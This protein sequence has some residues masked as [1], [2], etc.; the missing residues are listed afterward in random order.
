MRNLRAP[1]AKRVPEIMATFTTNLRKSDLP[2][3]LSAAD[4]HSLYVRGGKRLLDIVASLA[5]LVITS[6]L[7]ALSALLVRLTSRGPV[8]FRQT[9]VGYYGR[10]FTL[11]KFRTMVEGSETLGSAV[12]VDHD[13]RLTPVGNFLRRT[14]LDEL[15][16]FIN[17][18]RGEMSFVG[19][20][21]RVPSEIDMDDPSERILLSVRPGLTSYASIHHRME[22]D[23]CAR[24]P[25]PQT[26]H[27][28][29]LLP[30]K[31]SLDC[32][33]VQNLTLGLDVELL[34]LTF[35][36]VCVPG[37]SLTKGVRIFGQEVWPYDRGGQM[38]LELAVYAGAAWMAYSF[39]YE[40]GF[41]PL[42]QRQLWLYIAFIPALRVGVNR[43]LRIYDMMW[44]YVTVEDAAHV[45]MALA[46]VSLAL[47]A[48]RLG[49]PTSSWVATMFHVPLSV[50][51]LEYTLALAGALGLRGLRRMLYMLHHQYQPLPEEPRRVLILGAGLLGL[52][53]AQ[54]IRPY[55]HIDLVGFLDDDPT[56]DGR[57]LA[58]CRVLGNSGNL[59]SLC[60]RHK[61]T[62]LVICAKT[63]D[64][65][66]LLDLFRRCEILRIKLHR[67]PRLDQI[68]RGETEPAMTAR[69]PL[70]LATLRREVPE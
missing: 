41:P 53:T 68:L 36:L 32:Q 2:G 38:L 21:P 37:K 23:Y 40:A 39:R 8:L 24:H 48:L 29:E 35:M 5:G 22:A 70:S 49:L 66:Q 47:Y 54:D 33:Y 61:V 18:L 16:Q 3:A 13:R 58:G 15:P 6:P 10:R 27:R 52:T 59:E 25:N 12:V 63:I 30:Q 62:D 64:P 55:P 20:R 9:R 14:K 28:T 69:R 44:R 50:I 7:L 60:A 1:E 46:P 11:Y 67:L 42:Y 56:K 17:V 43:F 51:S 57:F 19:P 34:L 65:H 45:A 4:S 31:R 26:V